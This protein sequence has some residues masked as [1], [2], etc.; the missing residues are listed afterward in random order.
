MVLYSS[1]Y[2]PRNWKS[3]GASVSGAVVSTMDS[4]SLGPK[5]VFSEDTYNV[6]RGIDDLTILEGLH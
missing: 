4:V 5:L 6:P 1:F 3:N 2:A